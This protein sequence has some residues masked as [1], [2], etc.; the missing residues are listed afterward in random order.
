MGT[1]GYSE[2]IDKLLF[3]GLVAC[4]TRFHFTAAL[5]ER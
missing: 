4:D 5:G 1:K 2:L 3:I